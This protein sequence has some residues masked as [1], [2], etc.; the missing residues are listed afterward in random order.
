MHRIAIKWLLALYFRMETCNGKLQKMENNITF[1]IIVIKIHFE[2]EQMCQH[3][4]QNPINM[5]G[6]LLKRIMLQG[7]LCLWSSFTAV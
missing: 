4:T 6:R 3:N 7:H 1:E 5:V 2:A